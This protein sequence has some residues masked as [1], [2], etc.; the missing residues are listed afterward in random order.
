MNRYSK[1]FAFSFALA[2]ASALQAAPETAP[3]LPVIAI[4]QVETKDLDTYVMWIARMNEV[5]KAKTGAERTFRVYTGD[6]AGPDSGAVVAVS[7]AES[8]AALAKT[9]KIFSEDP[10]IQAVRLHMN[11]IRE[12][13]TRTL[14]K[15]VRF[16]GR[17]TG[18]HSFHTYASVSDE[19]GYLKSLDGLRVLFDEHNFKDLKVNVYRVMAGRS[20]Y[21][22]LIAINTPSAERLAAFMDAMS[23]EA[24]VAE[25]L[26]TTAKTRT[27]VRNGTY[28]EV[29]R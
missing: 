2:S 7:A 1:L 21:T 19:A 12:M 29:T 28:H 17:L 23:T 10:D 22:H 8:F 18:T 9:N 26:A 4:T 5:M 13:G 27:V 6:A 15:A 16:D 20:D 24:W 3:S 25:W 14:L 11:A